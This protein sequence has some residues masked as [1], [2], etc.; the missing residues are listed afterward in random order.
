[1]LGLI[2]NNRMI[3]DITF[4]TARFNLSVVGSDFINDCCFGEDLS[5]WLVEA[6]NVKHIDAG[7]ICME[8]F[9]WA[10]YAKYDGVDYLICV[11]G[12]PDESPDQPNMG[13]W[14]VMLERKNSFIQKLLGK[15]KDC[16]SVT[17]ANTVIDILKEAGFSDVQIEP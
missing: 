13:E 11:A 14:H 1:M 17:F 10:N 12:S 7:V 2:E 5:Q 4:K 6:L 9:G 8:D 15:K 3:I 16:K